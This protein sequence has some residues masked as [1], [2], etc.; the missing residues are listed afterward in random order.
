MHYYQFNIG[1]YR[2]QTHHLTLVEHAIYRALIDTYY[3]TEQPLS[4]DLAKLMRSH[5]VRNADEK[6]A[7]ENVLEDFFLLQDDGYH[8]EACD[9]QLAKIYDKSEKARASA[10]ARWGKNAKG[11]RTQCE[12]DANDMLPNNPI[13]QD[14]KPTSKKPPAEAVDFSVFGLPESDIKE[15]K[16]I[17]RQNKGGKITQRV[18]NGLAK[19]FQAAMQMGYTMDY[20]LTEWETR[21]WKSFKAEWVSNRSQAGFNRQPELD[22]DSTDWINGINDLY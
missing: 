9:K 18:A 22:N 8:H 7:L 21:G 4:A 17:R 5:S 6:Q 19:E 10:K 16:R 20:L 13:T 14:P 11:M 12:S 2:R 1:D 15:I 3:L